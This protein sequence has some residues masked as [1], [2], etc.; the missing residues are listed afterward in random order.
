MFIFLEVSLAALR[1]NLET[2]DIHLQ[3]D[4]LTDK[5]ESL[6]SELR[7]FIHLSVNSRELIIR[8]SA[9]LLVPLGS[10]NRE[11]ESKMVVAKRQGRETPVKI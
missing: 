3:T 8:L 1:A 6:H 7:C 10:Y 11:K 5:G 4:F 2:H 9:K